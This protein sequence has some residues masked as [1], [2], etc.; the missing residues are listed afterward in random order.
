MRFASGQRL[1][2]HE[3]VFWL[4]DLNYRLNKLSYEDAVRECNSN[5]F[6]LLFYFDQ[7]SPFYNNKQI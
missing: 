7:V 2:N 1:Y 4:G 6:Q 3:I 5:R